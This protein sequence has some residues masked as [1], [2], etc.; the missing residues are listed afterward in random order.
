MQLHLKNNCTTLHLKCPPPQ[1]YE[2]SRA[3]RFETK[4]RAT[5]AVAVISR[6]QELTSGLCDIL[7]FCLN[8]AIKV[9]RNRLGLA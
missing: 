6:Q 5:D 9:V 2:H 1:P 7:D 8:T 3:E 4:A